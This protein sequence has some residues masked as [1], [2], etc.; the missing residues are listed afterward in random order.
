MLV[1]MTK[2]R[3]LGRRS[4]ADAVLGELQRLG[5]VELADARSAHSLDGLDGADMRF[6]R[7]EELGAALAQIEKLLEKAPDGAPSP[8]ASRSEP[9]QRQAARAGRNACPRR[10]G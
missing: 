4:S 9:T 10:P 2:V 6:A 5:V 1:P 8:A 3:I 7:R